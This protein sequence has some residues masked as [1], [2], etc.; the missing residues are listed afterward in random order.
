MLFVAEKMAAL[1]VV[2]QRLAHLGLAPFCLEVH[3]TKATKNHVFEQIK[4]ASE[5]GSAERPEAYASKA[6]EVR[7]LRGRLDR[8][9]RGLE[10]KNGAGFTLRELICRYESLARTAEPMAVSRAFTDS[11]QGQEDFALRMNA[12]ERL[13]SQGARLA[14]WGTSPLA[15]LKGSQY[16]QGLRDELPG[17]LDAYEGSLRAL[18]AAADAAAAALGMPE[19][20]SVEALGSLEA[21]ATSVRAASGLPAAW[22]CQGSLSSVLRDL[23]V[24]I[25]HR[26]ACLRTQRDILERRTESFFGL[27]SEQVR[28]AWVEASSAG[29]LRRGKAT[30]KVLSEL[31]LSS[32]EPVGKDDVPS[33]IAD[34]E[35]WER[36]SADMGALTARMRPC[37]EGFVSIDGSVAWGELG[38][39]VSSARSL[40]A[41]GGVSEDALRLTSG[42]AGAREAAGDLLDALAAE[43]MARAELERRIGRLETD[44][45]SW[46][47]GQLAACEAIRANLDGL[48]EWMGWNEAC[49]RARSLG[50]VQLVDHLRDHAVEDGT[51]D[52]FECGTFKTMAMAALDAT[53]GMNSFAGARFTEVVRQYARADKQL[54]ELARQEVCYEVA[55][56]TPDLSGPAGATPEAVALQRALRSRGRN[57]TIR[58]VFRECGDLV[59]SLCPCLLMSP[60]S[61]AQYL[62]PGKRQFDLVVFDEA[63]QLQTCKAVGALSRAREAVVVGDPKQMPPT[64]FFQGTS[65]D[66]DF[67]EVADLE[68]LLEDC[69]ALNMPQAYLRWHYRSRHES[70]IAFSNRRFYEGRMLTFP[71]ADDRTSHVTF[72]KV[73][74]TFDRGGTRT[75]RAEAEAVVAEVARRAKDPA[76]AGESV[77]VVTFNIPQQSLI[78]D[79]FQRACAAD[80]K[81]DSWAHEGEEPVFIKNLENVQ[82]DERDAILFSITYAPDEGGRMS[83]NF[84]PINREGGWRRLNVA[85]T[86][87][88]R[89][90]LVFSSIEPEDIDLNRTSSSG[91]ASLRAFLEYARRG[92]F[93]SVS[94][95]DLQA[96]EDGDTIAAELCE[97]L[98]KLGYRTRQNVGRSA[99]RVDV[100]VVDPADD[101]RYLAGILLDGRTYRMSGTTRD[102]EIAQPEILE[103]LGWKVMRVWAIDWWEGPEA[104]VDKVREFLEQALAER[105]EKPPTPG[106][107]VAPAPAPA[108]EPEP[109]PMPAPEPAAVEPA[110]AP[111]PGPVAKPAPARGP[112]SLPVIEPAPI[113]DATSVTEPRRRSPRPRPRRGQARP[114]RPA[115]R[116]SRHAA[117][118]AAGGADGPAGRAPRRRRPPSADCDYVLATVEGIDP[119]ADILAIERTELAQ[120]FDGVLA[121]EAP[122]EEELLFRRVA[123]LYGIARDGLTASTRASRRASRP[124]TAGR[125][126][127]AGRTIDWRREQNP[128]GLR[129][130]PRAAG[131]GREAVVRGDPA[132]GDRSGG[133]GAHRAG[134]ALRAGRPHQGGHAQPRL[135]APDARG[136]R[137]PAEGPH[138]RHTARP[139]PPGQERL[140]PS[141]RRRI[142]RPSP[143]ATHKYTRRLMAWLDVALFSL[144]AIAASGPDVHLAARTGD[145]W[146]VA[147]GARTCSLAQEGGRLRIARRDGSEQYSAL[148]PLL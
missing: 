105:G 76:L 3:S 114:S 4:A 54:R 39:A 140:L 70:L 97:E 119:A 67:E 123:R 147:S 1:E 27:R 131:R 2:E 28:A 6:Q 60:L 84:G 144:D 44:E 101:G 40:M 145:A 10:A 146:L 29:M 17:L 26:G 127:R 25:E 42:H 35:A 109:M 95:G 71:S 135:L 46:A 9:A 61:V 92:S 47:E 89:D 22:T 141:R 78:D 11:I 33:F 126:R 64:S 21:A 79:L 16:H 125:S 34:L 85:V 148:I 45:A 110:P 122:I 48:R 14:P 80:P 115:R 36:V 98:G 107:L 12:A 99:Y 77:G 91:P 81:L 108:A 73:A 51:L 50:L 13:L 83:M 130:L 102:R 57:V 104:V 41:S 72:R 128:K 142:G 5:I 136:K 117:D 65:S 15:P 96:D 8:Y 113:I 18:E 133:A 116:R 69:L 112:A 118:P 88:R 124:R 129:R 137:V 59:F 32:R 143:K 103:G 63:S 86:R 68:S 62:E 139:V 7:A 56:R 19:A 53:E 93:T 82:G 52:S 132:R 66:E 120:T 37:L 58:S 49:E 138:P 74:G 90:M 134:R 24:L 121:V 75:N 38:Q 87:A 23:G 111:E 106:S 94:M 31:S 100:G 43:R 55:A 30:A 20:R